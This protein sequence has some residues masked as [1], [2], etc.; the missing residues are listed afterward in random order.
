M[1]L[2]KMAVDGVYHE[3]QPFDALQRYL[4]L[5]GKF[6]NLARLKGCPEKNLQLVLDAIE[7]VK[8]LMKIESS[9]APPPAPH[10]PPAPVVGA[11]PPMPA[12]GQPPPPMA[13]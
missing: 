4:A 6:Y 12:L 1:N 3:P 11:P 8:G 7:E 5:A 2:R 10:G 9:G 13:A